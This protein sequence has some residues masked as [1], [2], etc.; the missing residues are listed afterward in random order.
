MS[1]ETSP[2]HHRRRIALAAVASLLAFATGAQAQP[3]GGPSIGVGRITSER[4]C[5]L[6]QESEGRSAVVV[7]PYV[8]AAASSWR[9]WL[10]RDCVDN[11]ASI[12]TSLEA[13]LASSGKFIVKPGGATY[14]VSG[15]ISDVGGE[16]GPAPG[17]PSSRDGYSISSSKMFVNMD[18]TVRDA[19]GRIVYG[20]LLTKSLE[21]GSDISTG[22]FRATSS[23]SGQALY[24]QLQHEV[25]LAVAR[26]V[27]FHL[28]PMRVTGGDGRQIQLS[29]GAPMLT[30]GTIVMATSADGATTLRYNVTSA[31]AGMATA[32]L[33]GDGD[34][35]RIGPG[36]IATVIEADDPAAN[37][38]R[39][40][41]VELPQ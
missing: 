9:T 13:A 17:A 31:G 41:R 34:P 20:A 12:R 27:A 36:S 6:Y 15:R 30:L 33:D 7:S 32:Q 4:T 18:V 23:Q 37:G 19:A 1:I 11:F 10:V 8:I 5:N 39:F 24:T 2:G 25:A 35:S 14:V 40:K 22:G 16:G 29:Y 38:R 26:Q 21:T 3:R 28:V